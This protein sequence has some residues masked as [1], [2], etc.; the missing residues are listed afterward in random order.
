[1]IAGTN[2]SAGVTFINSYDEYGQ[3]GSSNQGRFG[4]TGQAFIP[5]AGAYDYKAR[6][7][8]PYIGRFLQTD[9][10]GY[11]AGMNLYAYAGGDPINVS[12]WDG[13]GWPSYPGCYTTETTL[14]DGMPELAG[15]NCPPPSS[16]F[17]DGSAGGQGNPAGNLPPNGWN[18]QVPKPQNRTQTFSCPLAD[19]LDK[20]TD[21]LNIVSGAA[22]VGAL[23]TVEAPPV[24]AGFALVGQFA[25]VG[26]FATTGTAV[27]LRIREGDYAGAVGSVGN[28]VAGKMGASMFRQAYGALGTPRESAKTLGGRS[29]DVLLQQP[30]NGC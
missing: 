17:G 26:A 20:A 14:P 18:G 9:P 15:P 30:H 12:D 23:A 6:V 2:S 1:M 22:D 16:S 13:L 3:P 5:E 24:A 10:T 21:A 29:A 11:G 7:Y 28:F 25:E 27:F 8:L 19:Q 4:Y